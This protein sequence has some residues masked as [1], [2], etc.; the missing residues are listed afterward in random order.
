MKGGMTP[1]EVFA[2]DKLLIDFH[3]I[4]LGDCMFMQSLRGWLVLV[5][6][7]IEIGGAFV[8]GTWP[9]AYSTTT[10]K[11]CKTFGISVDGIFPETWLRQLGE[12]ADGDKFPTAIGFL[13]SAQVVTDVTEPIMVNFMGTDLFKT[14]N[15]WTTPEDYGFT[16]KPE[17]AGKTLC[18]ACP[19]Y[20]YLEFARR[21]MELSSNEFDVPISAY[22]LRSDRDFFAERIEMAQQLAEESANSVS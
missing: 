17:L 9:T 7:P 4:D 2:S 6:P 1:L 15:S 11:S 16:P 20:D 5:P 13:S 8:S 3:E 10:Y 12:Y 18:I 22:S 21:Y 19:S 14:Y